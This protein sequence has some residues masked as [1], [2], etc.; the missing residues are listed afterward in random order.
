MKDWIF[1]IWAMSLLA[2]IFLGPF[3]T[4]A[5]IVRFIFQ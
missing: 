4:I 3:V 1:T 2:V 5:L